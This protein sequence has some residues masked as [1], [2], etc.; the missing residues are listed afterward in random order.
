MATT[1]K[2]DAPATDEFA[3]WS[4]VAPTSGKSTTPRLRD[5]ANKTIAIVNCKNVG[6]NDAPKFVVVTSEGSEYDVPKT[7]A[8]KV[9]EALKQAKQNGKAGF[10]A[11]IV[12]MDRGIKFS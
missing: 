9:V 8:R 3:S 10:R 4:D 2:K 11:T 5:M 12:A 1:A 7:T 6:T